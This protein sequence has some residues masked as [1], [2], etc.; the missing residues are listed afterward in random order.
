M[1]G[2]ILGFEVMERNVGTTA[3]E[4]NLVRQH[5]PGS[6]NH[7]D[8]TATKS[9]SLRRL[10]SQP[11]VS[12]DLDNRRLQR[13]SARNSTSPR[14]RLSSSTSA[15]PTM[16][17]RC[18][19]CHQPP[20]LS[21]M[22]G[23]TQSTESLETSLSTTALS[24]RSGSALSS[25]RGV[26]QPNKQPPLTPRA[27]TWASRKQ[28]KR[29]Q[30]PLAIIFA[31]EEANHE[32]MGATASSDGVEH[33]AREPERKSQ[34]AHQDEKV[35]RKAE[36]QARREARSQRREWKQWKRYTPLLFVLYVNVTRWYL[37]FCLSLSLT[38]THT[39]IHTTHTCPGSKT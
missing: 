31:A 35:L 18:D 5:Q 6:E 29:L 34:P 27:V 16:A 23:E 1:E 33:L 22:E 38:H 9:I 3:T 7:K 39:H 20:N 25:P 24:S 26:V 14:G 11:E 12:S 30:K 4:D 15:I 32:K 36:R 13:K 37:W 28:E 17:I 21:L 19:D 10:R 8:K 2:V